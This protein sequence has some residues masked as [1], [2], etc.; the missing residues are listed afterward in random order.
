MGRTELLV[1]VDAE[2]QRVTEVSLAEHPAHLLDVVGEPEIAIQQVADD[3]APG[4]ARQHTVP[5]VLAPADVLGKVE[6]PDALILV[7]EVGDRPSGVVVDPVA[8]DE[9]LEVAHRLTERAAHGVLQQWSTVPGR[10]DDHRGS[11]LAHDDKPASSRRCSIVR[12]TS[13]PSSAVLLGGGPPRR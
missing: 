13:T 12:T 8:D 3:P 2:S 10:R 6:E 9:H 5:V 1:V 4:V 11:E 7:A